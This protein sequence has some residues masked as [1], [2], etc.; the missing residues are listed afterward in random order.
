MSNNLVE[1]HK[2]SFGLDANVAVLI[3]YLGGIVISFIPG[4]KFLAWAVPLVIFFMES[5]SEFIKFHSMQ[6]FVLNL[7]GMLLGLLSRWILGAVVAAIIG[8]I[9]AIFAIIAVYRGWK[10]EEYKIPYISD[11]ALKIIEMLG[12]KT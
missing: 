9:I 2:S 6:S 1:P 11:L 5:K 4:L 3:A 8:I 10:Y 7:A 12:A